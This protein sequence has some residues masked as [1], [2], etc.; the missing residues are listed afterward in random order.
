MFSILDKKRAEAVRAL[1]EQCAF[2]SNKES[3]NAPE[4]NAFE[5]VGRFWNKSREDSQ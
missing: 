3:I 1:Q 4:Y 2:L 5:G